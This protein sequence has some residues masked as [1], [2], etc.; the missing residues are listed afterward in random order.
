MVSAESSAHLRTDKPDQ[1]GNVI[2][3]YDLPY[4]IRIESDT[5]IIVQYSRAN[6]GKIPMAMMTTIDV[7]W[8]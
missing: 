6:T 5:K 1:I 2:I 7:H 4:G 3:P 8:S